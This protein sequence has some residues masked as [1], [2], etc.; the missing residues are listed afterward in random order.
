MSLNHCHMTSHGGVKNVKT[1][2]KPLH[3]YLI[4][5]LFILFQFIQFLPSSFL[6]S[7]FAS[8][9]TSQLATLFS[10][11]SGSGQVKWS[12]SED[13]KLVTWEITV[14]QNESE[15]EAAPSVDVVVPAHVSAPQLVTATPSGVFTPSGN[16]HRFTTPYSTSAQTLTLTFTTVVNDLTSQNLEFKIGASIQAKDNPEAISLHTITIPNTLAQLEAQRIAEE[17]V[18]AE[19]LA[20]EKAEAERIAQEEADK[21]AEEQRKAEEKAAQELANLEDKSETPPDIKGDTGSSASEENTDT[22][23]SEEVNPTEVEYTEVESDQAVSIKQT[24]ERMSILSTAQAQNYFTAT[25]TSTNDHYSVVGV[26][27]DMNDNVHLILDNDKATA[28]QTRFHSPMLNGQNAANYST[29]FNN[30]RPYWNEIGTSLTLNL[31][32]TALSISGVRLF[33]FNL[34]P[35]T[36]FL[37]ETNTL[38]MLNQADGFSIRGMTFNLNLDYSITKEVIPTTATIGDQLIY[39]ITVKNNGHLPLYNVDIFDEVPSE[40]TA[41]RVRE[42]GEEWA[43]VEMSNGRILL[44]EGISLAANGGMRTF[45]VMAHV[46]EGAIHGDSLTNTATIGGAVAPKSDT[47][48][49]DIEAT[50]VDITKAII[51][52]DADYD[53]EFEFAYVITRPG[54]YNTDH[55]YSPVNGT[56]TLGNGESFTLNNLPTDALITLSEESGNYDVTVSVEDREVHPNDKG[57]YPFDLAGLS[58]LSILVTN[59]LTVPREDFIVTKVW[60]GGPEENK[61]PVELTL[62]RTTDGIT[63]TEVEALPDIVPVERPAN[64]YT[65]TWSNLPT[66]MADG[67]PYTYYFT[68][69]EVEGYTR[70][71]AKDI[72]LNGELYGVFDQ[73]K[74]KV[75]NIY[76]IPADDIEATKTWVN[77]QFARPDLWFQL[78]RTIENS[79]VDEAVDIMKLP[80]THAIEDTVSV[81]F[82]NVDKTDSDGQA[83]SFYVVEGFYNEDTEEFTPGVP[84]HFVQTGSGLDI[85]NTYV[86]PLI[87]IFARKIWNGGPSIDHEAVDLIL[88]RRIA[89][90]DFYPVDDSRPVVNPNSGNHTEFNYTWTNLPATD[91]QGNSYEYKVTEPTVPENYNSEV[92]PPSHNNN[93][94]IINNI[95]TIPQF[96]IVGTKSWTNDTEAYRPDSLTISLYREIEGGEIEFVTETTT[97]ILDEWFYNFGEQDRTDR[98]GNVYSYSIAETVPQ[99][100]NEEY[101][102]AYF[103]DDVLHLDVENTLV[104]GDFHIQKTDSNGN[105]IK[106]NPA[107]FRL[108]QL[109]PEEANPYTVTLSTDAEGRLVFTDLLAGTYLLEETKAPL[110]FNLY[111]DD[112]VVVVEKGVNGETIVRVDDVLITEEHPL[113]IRNH[114]SQSL[115]DTGSMGTTL[116]TLLGLALMG[117]TVYG[118]KKSKIKKNEQRSE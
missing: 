90:E 23:V 104:M 48:T 80:V 84:E 67:S 35:M 61:H 1:Q 24:N 6:S 107:E 11:D 49:V 25:G 2:H 83:Y 102:E 100:Y 115:P 12:L 109:D 36:G 4:T 64:E 53:E 93:I 65:Y 32:G 59:E 72:E 112:F 18:E 57:S 110:G 40:I 43:N 15:T 116:F 42:V 63:L 38:Q 50:H 22:H 111:P 16:T 74:G 13:G 41:L 34:G 77:G 8:A 76:T 106:S 69:T 98:N 99:N 44:A 81:I 94:W 66:E 56:F 55:Y 82:L 95:Y 68:E 7:T 85:T 118:F 79:E 113:V 75:T 47:A 70:E 58:S 89:G 87:D 28:N 9:E 45:E 73:Y 51:G 105:P 29:N 39:T 33:D 103:I 117:G 5:V 62:W 96:K 54:K 114:P 52:D 108:T 60:Q 97:S 46:N 21:L 91:I 14:S 37:R 92:T 19:R 88:S 10:N 101:D 30:Y 31:N 78:R 27:I 71:Y 17:K 20:A 26:Y 86:S 3:T